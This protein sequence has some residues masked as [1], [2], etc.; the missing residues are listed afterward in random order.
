MSDSLTLEEVRNQRAKWLADLQANREAA[1]EQVDKYLALASAH[2]LRRD[3][4][5]AEIRATT[6]RKPRQAKKTATGAAEGRE[7]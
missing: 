2:R 1:Q 4:I 6:P 5:D 3:E 7:A